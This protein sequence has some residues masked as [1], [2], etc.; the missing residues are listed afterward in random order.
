LHTGL[1]AGDAPAAALA[2]ATVRGDGID[3]AGAAFVAHGV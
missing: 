3:P 1:A 2:A